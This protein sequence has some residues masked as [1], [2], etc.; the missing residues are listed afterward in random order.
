MKTWIGVDFDGT[1]AAYHGYKGK[2]LGKPVDKMVNRVLQW[3]KDGKTVK[4]FTARAADKSQVQA[5]KD[6]LKANDLPDLEVTNV[7][8]KGMTQLWDDRAVG[9]K[10]NTGEPK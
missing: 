6:W 5:I 1:L 3:V 10:I 7:K 9:I 4:I 2:Q 8:D